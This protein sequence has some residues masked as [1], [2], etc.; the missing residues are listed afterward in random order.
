MVNKKI[1]KCNIYIAEARPDSPA[2]GYRNV[3]Q[4][5]H[6]AKTQKASSLHLRWEGGARFVFLFEILVISILI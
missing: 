5:Y 4:K 3:P 1:N 6:R 2:I